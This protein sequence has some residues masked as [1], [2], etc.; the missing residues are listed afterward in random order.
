MNKGML[1]NPRYGRI[2]LF[3]FPFALVIEGLGAIIEYLGYVSLAF[4]LYLGTVDLLFAAA[5]LSAAVLLGV[6]I[7]TSAL[8]VEEMTYKRYPSLKMV[9]VLFLFGFL[10]NFG[11]RQLNAWWRFKATFDYISGKKSWGEMT[12]TGFKKNTENKGT[13]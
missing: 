10:E 3:A 11:Y 4:S 8:L 9:S 2:G 12:R 1:F 5:F 7:S 13:P 6:V